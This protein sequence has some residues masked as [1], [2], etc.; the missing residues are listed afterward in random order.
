MIFEKWIRG[1]VL[2]FLYSDKLSP[3]HH[4]LSERLEWVRRGFIGEIE[5]SAAET[6]LGQPASW[7]R[8]PGQGPLG[9]TPGCKDLM[10][11]LREPIS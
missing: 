9:Q 1:G 11:N 4:D 7:T 10:K 5:T 2:I 6:T 8:S 3:M